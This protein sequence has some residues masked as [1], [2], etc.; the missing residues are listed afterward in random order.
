MSVLYLEWNQSAERSNKY[1]N[2]QHSQMNL[3]V[4]FRDR[5]CVSDTEIDITKLVKAWASEQIDNKGILLQGCRS[6]LITFAS[7]RHQ[8]RGM[9]PFVRFSYEEKQ[10]L[11][12]IPCSVSVS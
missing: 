7:I 3:Y 12:S 4:E 2:W 5:A 6:N 8:D 10:P 1:L 11:V 9:R